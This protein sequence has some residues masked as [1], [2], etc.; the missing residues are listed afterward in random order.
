VTAPVLPPAHRTYHVDVET[1]MEIRHDPADP[2]AGRTLY[3]LAVPYDVELDVSDWWED[4]TELFR[5]GSFAKTITSRKRAVPLLVHHERRGLG[6]GA[7]TELSEE[8][9]GLHA[10]FQL[11]N[12]P[13]ADEVLELY[14]IGAISGL[15]IG[16]EPVTHT[17][18]HG[19]Q[20]VPP[21][22]RDLHERTEVILHEV[23]VCNFPAYADAGVE[24]VRALAR[25]GA[26]SARAR[27]PSVATLAATRAE[28]VSVVRGHVDRYGRVV[29][30]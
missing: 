7:A 26:A 27:H 12:T 23:S 28:G 10:A 15:S 16:F 13:K 18:T 24:G 30:R 8:E 25:H 2:A 9:D 14:K 17:V 29:R 22:D 19:P 3:G 20:R 21:S 4:Y 1:R 11:A 5:R 6:I